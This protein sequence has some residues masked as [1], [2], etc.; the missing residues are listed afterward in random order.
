MKVN[1]VCVYACVCVCVCVC[2]CLCVCE[3][4]FWSEYVLEQDASVE[5]KDQEWNDHDR[6]VHDTIFW[7]GGEF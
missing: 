5:H 2:V 1:D 6:R 4:Q 7:P 3:D